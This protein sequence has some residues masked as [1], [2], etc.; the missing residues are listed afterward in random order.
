MVTDLFTGPSVVYGLD[1]VRVL[2]NKLRTVVRWINRSTDTRLA[3]VLMPK[4]SAAIAHHCAGRPPCSGHGIHEIKIIF[5][6]Q[7]SKLLFYSQF[8]IILRQLHAFNVYKV[9]FIFLISFIHSF[10][11]WKFCCTEDATD[12]RGLAILG[13]VFASFGR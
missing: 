12:G 13:Q 6:A 11:R 7:C 3:S 1:V 2:V 8:Q 9:E 4:Y 5:D 10:F